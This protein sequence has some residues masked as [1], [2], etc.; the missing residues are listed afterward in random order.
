[1]KSVNA[2]DFC[3]DMPQV[4]CVTVILYHDFC[5]ICGS[6]HVLGTMGLFGRCYWPRKT[7]SD[8]NMLPS[9]HLFTL[10]T[11]PSISQDSVDHLIV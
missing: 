7:F 2:S 6:E 9:S 8:G 1:V 4:I 10:Q 5:E 11:D 3:W